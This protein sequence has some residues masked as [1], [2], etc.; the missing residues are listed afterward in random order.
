M[1][2]IAA[3]KRFYKNK[4]IVVLGGAGF[5]GSNLSIKLVEYGA[6]VTVVDSLVKDAGGNVFNIDQIKDKIEFLNS[7]I[8]AVRSLGSLLKNSSLVFN[9]MGH[10]DHMASLKDP[11]S[12]LGYNASNHA[13]F[14]NYCRVH[15]SALK[16]VYLGTRSQYGVPKQKVVSEEAPMYPRDFHSAHKILG[17]HYHYL[18]NLHFKQPVVILRIT[19]V[20][21]PRQSMRHGSSSILNGFIRDIMDNKK[22]RIYGTY[23]R[24]K[25]FIYVDDLVDTL[26]LVGSG[27]NFSGQIFNLGGQPVK[28]GSAVE[29]IIRILKKGSYDITPFPNEVKKID[30]GDI[31]L[32]NSRIYRAYACRF[33]TRLHKGLKDT[34]DSYTANKRYYW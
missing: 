22:A 21:G 6:K 18:Y 10:T 17:E 1:K 9:C 15:N 7:D 16:I 4:K 11:G 33:V 23:D 25:D 29:H 26:L 5:I 31:V 32:D 3:G 30:A 14:L 34:I 8:N 20:Y 24:I 28:L 12:D 19:N 2:R 27:S 13:K